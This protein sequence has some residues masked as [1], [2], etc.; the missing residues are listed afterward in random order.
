[1]FRPHNVELEQ[2]I[3]GA[4]LTGN[5]RYHQ[6]SGIV[7]AKDF[8]DPVHARIW[9][10]ISARIRKEHTASPVTLK[11]DLENDEGLKL[12]GGTSYLAKLAGAS[13]SGFAVH[14]YATEL[15]GIANERRIVDAM[16]EA[17]EQ[18]KERKPLSEVKSGLELALVELEE[19][20]KANS[21]SLNMA[22]T[23]AIARMQK[24]YEGGAPTGIQTGLTLLDERLGGLFA[25]DLLILAGRP[26]MGKTAL[27]TSLSLRVARQKKPVVIV[28]L[29]M[30]D[31]GLAQ[32]IL[33]ELSGVPYFNYRRAHEMSEADFR[34]TVDA[35]K[36]N[37]GLP[38]EIVPAHV[39]DPGG[40][41]SALRQIDQKYSEIGG[42]AMVM[43]DYLQLAVGKGKDTQ[44]RIAEL[45]KSFKN[46]ARMLNCPF[47]V[48]S[49]LSRQVEYRDNKRPMLSDL[50]DSGQIEQDADAVL[51]CYR[52]HYYKSREPE[53][54]D[55]GQ[56]ADQLAAMAQCQNLMEVVTAKQ[57][58]GAIGSDT[59]GCAI[60]SNRFWNL[61]QQTEAEF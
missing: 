55:P 1:M 13:I 53:K 44:E 59:I 61:E 22:F 19:Q 32:R 46:M 4:V 20:G 3:L 16:H 50:R 18:I 52:D 11:V 25:P 31:E 45:S 49:Q 28:S 14:D 43:V 26:S 34:K 42:I 38:I 17:M 57:R 41:Y 48:L 10:N 9:K 2:Q 60:A 36:E 23:N 15:A 51:F 47:I 5:E 39:R 8:F 12:L 35:A 33:S 29:E 21:I 37:F 24:A 7:S 54:E 6:I 58:F 56:R 30:D 27:A 40:I